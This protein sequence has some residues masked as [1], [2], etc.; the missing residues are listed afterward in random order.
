MTAVPDSVVL[1]SGFSRRIAQLHGEAGVRWLRGLPGLV[2]AFAERWS[3]RVLAPFEALSY[4]YVAPAVRA[5]GSHVVLKAGVPGSDVLQE[6]E[7]LRHLAGRG[8]VRLLESDRE[9]GVLLLE[10]LEPGTSLVEVRD[11]R[12]ATSIAADVM[13][14]LWTPAPPEHGFPSVADWA[15][16]LARLRAR[17]EGGA[18]PFPRALVETAESLFGD[19][20]GSMAE[21]VLLHGD[22]HHRNIVAAR[23]KPWLALDPKGVVGEPA[24]EVGALLRNPMP[25]LLAIA[26]PRRILAARLDQLAEELGFDR[27]RLAGWALAQAVLSAWWSLDDHGEGW[28]PM[29]A[30]AEHLSGLA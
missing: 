7:A 23:R 12:R 1:R 24:Y 29:I 8:V 17:F 27:S 25:E 22:L 18:G 26:Q 28:E 11:D 15:S 16:G 6:E 21:P 2:D 13:R 20:L 14:R 9:R 10:R 19:L 4:A 3:L 5:D 30:C